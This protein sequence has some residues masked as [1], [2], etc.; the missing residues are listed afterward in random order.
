MK[1]D[2]S[3][4][5][6]QDSSSGDSSGNNTNTA[7]AKTQ[8]HHPQ[9]VVAGKKN[10][11]GGAASG[12]NSNSNNNRK[13]IGGVRMG[14][15]STTAP[16]VGAANVNNSGVG[17]KLGFRGYQEEGKE[18]TSSSPPPSAAPA[19][20]CNSSSGG[21]AARVSELVVVATAG[22][23]GGDSGGLDASLSQCAAD[24]PAL[25][26]SGS[27]FS[28]PSVPSPV[29]L[30]ASSKSSAHV[31]HTV[32]ATP[33]S[34]HPSS[35]SSNATS[36]SYS[37]SAASRS[38]VPVLR[39]SSS[40][41]PSSTSAATSS[42]PSS[43]GTST[44]VSSSSPSAAT[45]GRTANGADYAE[46]VSSSGHIQGNSTPVLKGGQSQ[47]GGDVK[48]AKVTE[49]MSEIKL[50]GKGGAGSNKNGRNNSGRNSPAMIAQ[51]NSPPGPSSKEKDKAESSVH[52]AG[53][54]GFVVGPPG[55][56]TTGGFS[57][58]ASNTGNR[59]MQ[60]HHPGGNGQR[61]KK[62]A[63]GNSGNNGPSGAV[64]SGSTP[65]FASSSG[66]NSTGGP[67]VGLS[68]TN[69]YFYA[70][71]PSTSESDLIGMC[72]MFGDIVSV[73]VVRDEHTKLCR[74]FGFVM[75]ASADVTSHA[76]HG[77]RDRGVS[78]KY[79]KEP[80][81][82]KNH[83]LNIH[84]HA[85]HHPIHLGPHMSQPLHQMNAAA[86][87]LGGS[88]GAPT[89]RSGNNPSGAY[90]YGPAANAMYYGKMPMQVPVPMHMGP[91]GVPMGGMPVAS[92]PSPS[93][94]GH[95][96]VAP[97]VNNNPAEVAAWEDEWNSSN[98]ANKNKEAKNASASKS[99][100]SENSADEEG[101]EMSVSS[102]NNS[103]AMFKTLEDK[104]STNL[105]FANLPLYL[106]AEE[107]GGMLAPYG[108]VASP[109]IMRME[110]GESRGIGFARMRS[111]AVCDAIIR[112]F[113]GALFPGM[114]VPLYCNYAFSEAQRNFRRQPTGAQNQQRGPYNPQY[115]PQMVN[116]YGQ[117]VYA[118]Q[119]QMP[120][121]NVMAE[122]NGQGT[123]FPV[124]GSEAAAADSEVTS[125]M[126]SDPGSTKRVTDG[127][128]E[129]RES[130]NNNITAGVPFGMGMYSGNMHEQQML[131]M[132]GMGMPRV[133]G[134]GMSPPPSIVHHPNMHP[135]GGAVQ[136]HPHQQMHHGMYGGP[137]P[138]PQM[139]ME[140]MMYGMPAMVGMPGMPQ[141]QMM[142]SPA[143]QSGEQQS[144][145]EEAVVSSDKQQDGSEES[146][147][148]NAA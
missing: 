117:F 102:S 130:M 36:S 43:N 92:S 72:A 142:S 18:D 40:S 14:N 4:I 16:V 19:A 41:Q 56:S 39:S 52:T 118:N 144:A 21:S 119:F 27:S 114:E 93:A 99:K 146:K 76:L 73:R 136:M 128:D 75:F 23:G 86:G 63:A 28:S 132:M 25:L 31:H 104:S 13:V 15:H 82:N 42:T 24:H 135:N 120:A 11:A 131:H 84:H 65:G 60:Q 145:N 51:A 87:I 101:S 64:G 141:G 32:A 46:R 34:T 134:N 9:H 38:C 147:S 97:P 59:K 88:H 137:I 54:G 26:S 70:L 100:A 96:M 129:P 7:A 50:N 68:T 6:H 77:L 140:Q 44:G 124:S 3:Q 133:G 10:G 79:A 48:L 143:V 116:G 107:L 80:K 61:K 148:G 78:V 57:R 94:M 74:G 12:N 95:G 30:Q 71:E 91:A 90:F 123:D 106:G 112:D 109:H 127:K 113:N 81:F 47:E 1:L 111:R 37:S 108:E 22:V 66:G 89:M 67:R 17:P 122:G 69:L 2:T 126:S 98:N 62:G 20:N 45:M 33:S 8:P 58:T 35:S 121:E 55:D 105:Y 83:Q 85:N 29:L 5:V 115:F 110:N 125:P 103:A 139:G 53:G 138:H 49:T